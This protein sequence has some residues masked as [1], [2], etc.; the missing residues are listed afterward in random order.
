MGSQLSPFLSLET[1]FKQDRWELSAETELK[2]YD[3]PAQ[4]FLLSVKCFLM[5]EVTHFNVEILAKASMFQDLHSQC[6]GV[7]SGEKTYL[8]DHSNCDL[9][10]PWPDYYHTSQ[11][12]SF[13]SAVFLSF[14]EAAQNSS[15]LTYLEYK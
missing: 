11:D 12:T 8:I 4:Q 14:T 5:T 6:F 3:N 10:V 2:I 15:S 7:L 1:D 13:F 9:Q